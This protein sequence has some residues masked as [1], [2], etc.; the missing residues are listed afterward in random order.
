MQVGPN[1][2]VVRVLLSAPSRKSPPVP[3]FPYLPI[4]VKAGIESEAERDNGA[5][6]NVSVATGNRM[7]LA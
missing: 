2:T 1:L 7:S 3:T 5:A 4:L 6:E